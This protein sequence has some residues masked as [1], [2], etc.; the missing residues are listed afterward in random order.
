MR[1]SN[2]QRVVEEAVVRALRATRANDAETAPARHPRQTPACPPIARFAAVRARKSGEWTAQEYNHVGVCAYC[3]NLLRAFKTEGDALAVE[4]SQED[5][6]TSLNTGEETHVGLPAPAPP[7]AAK[8][9][10]PPR[11][12]Q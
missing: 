11:A 7:R 8:P 12:G 3:L 2:E 9:T 4:V 6:V 10:K 5:T 1:V